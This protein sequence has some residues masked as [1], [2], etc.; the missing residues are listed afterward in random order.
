MRWLRVAYLSILPDDRA[1]AGLARMQ[2]ATP[3]FGFQ[4][5]PRRSEQCLLRAFG[6]WRLYAWVGVVVLAAALPPRGKYQL[7]E[8]APSIN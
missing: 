3:Q 5:H 1:H 4:S 7:G 6:L 8:P 2:R